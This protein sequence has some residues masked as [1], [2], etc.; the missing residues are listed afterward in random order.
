MLMEVDGGEDDGSDFDEP[1]PPPKKK[2]AAPVK[3]AAPAKKGRGKKAV[4][5]SLQTMIRY[6]GADWN[7]RRVNLRKSWN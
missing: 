1:V 3:K 2:K 4:A 7:Q 6:T 5:V